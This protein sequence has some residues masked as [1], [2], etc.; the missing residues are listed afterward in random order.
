L[1][2]GLVRLSMW[3]SSFEHASRE[4]GYFSRSDVPKSTV[5]RLTQSAGEAYVRVQQAEVECIRRELPEPSQGPAVQQLSVDGAMVPL[6]GGEWAEVKTLVVGEICGQEPDGRIRAEGLS[7][8]SRLADAESF[9]SEALVETH[10]RGTETASVVVAVNDG[11]VWEQGF[12]DYRRAD[13]VRVLDFCHAAGYLSAAAQAVYGPGTK[14]CIEWVERYRH[15]LRYGD[16]GVVVEALRREREGCRGE[17]RQTVRRSLE[18]LE[19]RPEQIRYAEFELM[20]MPIGSGIVE[21]AN[22]LLVEGRLK[23]AGMHWAERNVSPMLALRTI[24]FNDRWEEAWPQ[25]VTRLRNSERRLPGTGG[26]PKPGWLCR[27]MCW[28]QSRLLYLC[29]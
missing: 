7:Y 14:G 25:I 17:A 15:E 6:V 1:H 20:G 18:Y 23:G 3:I 29:R 11:A 4:L 27:Q 2:E 21:S 19:R 16:P 28:S 22:K 13:A 5:R 10:R 26:G 24:A 9:T 8:F 12:V